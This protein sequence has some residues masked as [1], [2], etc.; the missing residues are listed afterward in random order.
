MNI[1]CCDDH[2]IFRHALVHLL[3]ELIEDAKCTE[4]SSGAELKQLCLHETDLDM[5][6]L[7]LEL[8]DGSGHSLFKHHHTSFSKG[9]VFVS[10]CE[11]S[12][13]ILSTLSDGALGFIPKSTSIAVL[14]Q[15]IQLILSGGQY[16][17][18]QALTQKAKPQQEHTNTHAYIEQLTSRQ[19]EI[20]KLATKGLTNR[21]IASLLTLSENTIK[22]HLRAIYRTLDVSNRTEA[23]MLWMASASSEERTPTS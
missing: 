19:Q 22:A 14:R 8:P 13:T 20:L 10:A 5:L 9:V 17:P 15:A 12:A 4:V 18:P 7:D 11:D 23:T 2:P 16:I 21:E 3:H 1:V 6:F